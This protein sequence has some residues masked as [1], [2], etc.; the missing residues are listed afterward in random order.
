MA[1]PVVFVIGASG[2]VGAAA[3]Q[4]LAKKYSDKVEIR[5]GVRHP[6]KADKLRVIPGVEVVQATMG[7]KEN[8]KSTLKGVDAL[9]IVTPGV[10]NRAQ[11]AIATAEAAKD[12]GVKYLLVVSVS[13]ARLGDTIFGAQFKEVEDKI[14]QL[15][16]P[17]TF[18]RLPYFLENLWGNKDSIKG[19]GAIYS[20]VDPEKPFT[21]VAV[22]DAGIAAAVI[23]ADPSKHAGKIYNI[24]SDRQS[25]KDITQGFSKALGKEIKYTRIPYE[26]TK[27]AFLGAGLQEWQ[28]NG[29]L[30]LMKLM[31]AGAPEINIADLSDFEKITGEKPTTF[32]DWISKNAPGFN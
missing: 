8:L 22:E 5:A 31:N 30:E 27:Q 18:L 24:L 15:G 11:L 9:Y 3:V 2:N 19:Q 7:D 10:E 12:A 20:P 26:A 23:L 4:N 6:D 16:V 29:L 13:T 28:V 17:Y 1:K 21:S 14:G 25:F 32:S